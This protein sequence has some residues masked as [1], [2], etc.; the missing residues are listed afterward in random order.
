VQWLIFGGKI[1]GSLPANIIAFLPPR[2]YI[3]LRFGVI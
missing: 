2:S 1:V 3:L